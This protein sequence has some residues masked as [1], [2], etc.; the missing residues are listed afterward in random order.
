MS[1]EA[2][3]K[4]LLSFNTKFGCIVADP[5]WPEIG[6]GKIKRGADRHYPLMTVDEIA[7]LP[8]T[9]IVGENAHMYMWIT[10]NFLARGAHVQ[11]AN[12]WGFRPVTVLTWK[13]FGRMGLGQ[14][15]RGTTEHVIFCVRGA[16]GYKTAPSGKRAQGVTDF[17]E[18]AAEVDGAW[19]EEPRPGEHSKKPI[20]IHEWAELVSPGPYL[21]MFARH[22]RKGWEA[23]G[24][25]APPSFTEAI[26]E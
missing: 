24:N 7:K 25:E 1:L 12:A 17:G 10:N 3:K 15:F 16:P 6:G 26:L 18:L 4:P 2:T 20:K 5:P 22:A 14:Y 13:K 23:W 19:W 21:E 8:V 11:V 9:G